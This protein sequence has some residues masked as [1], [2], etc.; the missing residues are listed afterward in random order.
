[1]SVC[2][3]L[4]LSVNCEQVEHAAQ[5]LPLGLLIDQQTTHRR[6][7]VGSMILY[8]RDFAVFSPIRK[9]PTRRFCLALLTAEGLHQRFRP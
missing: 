8:G 9:P 6:T 7:S 4:A 5:P 3:V 2:T 1:M